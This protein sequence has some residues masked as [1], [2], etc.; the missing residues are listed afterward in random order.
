MKEGK[1][2]HP[3]AQVAGRHDL[4]GAPA[5]VPLYALSPL[6]GR[7]AEVAVLRDLILGPSVRLLTVTGPVGVGKSRLAATVFN[8]VRSTFADG[9]YHI[10]LA[11]TDAGSDLA[12][13]LLR[14]VGAAASDGTTAEYAPRLRLAECLA[15]RKCLL[16]LD[17][18]EH[19]AHTATELLPMLLAACPG[20]RVLLASHEPLRMYGEH[21]LRVTPLDV[22]DTD[23]QPD[24]AGL[25][26]VASV[27]LFL[28]RARSARPGFG[29]SDRNCKAVSELCRK[30][31]GLPLAIEL[32]ARQLKLYSIGRLL[33]EL[34]DQPGLLHGDATDTLSRHRSMRTAVEW[35]CA[36]LNEAERLFL[37]RTAIFRGE[38]ELSD[39]EKVTGT[40]DGSHHDLLEALVDNGL[41]R[42]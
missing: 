29:L 10:D 9:A 22:P 18:C 5:A 11:A 3:A 24:L 6:V 32:A 2:L 40:A 34:D 14:V 7:H 38:F 39:V 21:V 19:I 1:T 35:S 16:L 27:E 15:G 25:E 12:E 33:S 28:Q 17:H 42:D 26:K 8:E 31:D 23:P 30:L 4:T 37:R 13:I 41:V 20:V 36:R